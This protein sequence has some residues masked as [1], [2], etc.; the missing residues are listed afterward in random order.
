MK[1]PFYK[2]KQSY[3]VH[4]CLHVKILRCCKCLFSEVGWLSY[5]TT[6]SQRNISKSH[7]N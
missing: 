5:G 1:Q 4:E 6:T 7:N 2:Q 3:A